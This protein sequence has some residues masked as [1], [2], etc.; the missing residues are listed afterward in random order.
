MD[1]EASGE[2]RLFKVL[3]EPFYLATKRVDGHSSS[4]TH[5]AIWRVLSAFELL[6][7]KLKR[8]QDE[9]VANPEIKTND[10]K[11]SNYAAFVKFSDY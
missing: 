3:L 10:D 4:G 9:T 11:H 6:Y 2:L 1:A 7:R 8:A 5:G